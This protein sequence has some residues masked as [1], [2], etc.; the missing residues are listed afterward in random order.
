MD[1][2]QTEKVVTAMDEAP[3]GATYG[4][5]LAGPLIGA[6]PVVGSRIRLH[7]GDEGDLAW[8]YD[9][10]GQHLVTKLVRHSTLSEVRLR[11]L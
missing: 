4:L 1:V 6:V 7:C 5:G 2:E 8:S 11:H 9:D 10:D 3:P